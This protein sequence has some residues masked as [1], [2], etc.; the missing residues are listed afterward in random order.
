MLQSFISAEKKIGGQVHFNLL[1][2]NLL[3]RNLYLL[4]KPF[5][6]FIN[7]IIAWNV[8]INFQDEDIPGNYR[9]FYMDE[10]SDRNGE[11]TF[12]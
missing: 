10:T 3:I 7:F 6:N 2:T 11:I 4:I 8:F 5:I 12:V 1:L 9:L